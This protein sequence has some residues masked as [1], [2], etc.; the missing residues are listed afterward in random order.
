MMIVK[1][2]WVFLFGIILVSAQENSVGD[3]ILDEM[4]IYITNNLTTPVDFLMVP[5]YDYPGADIKHPL[6]AHIQRLYPE[7]GSTRFTISY[8]K[9]KVQRYK[10]MP[11]SIMGTKV[12]LSWKE[13]SNHWD[14]F[15]LLTE[16]GCHT[17]YINENENGDYHLDEY[18]GDSRV[19]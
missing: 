15:F 19:L 12:N 7:E 8:D 13:K 18:S 16:D 3:E 4:C 9:E 14:Y 10:G 6:K 2:F 5:Y 17:R 11:S 1:S